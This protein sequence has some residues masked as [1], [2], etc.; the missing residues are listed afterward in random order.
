M[1]KVSRLSRILPYLTFTLLHELSHVTWHQP[2]SPAVND[3]RC[4]F[5]LNDVKLPPMKLITLHFSTQL[6]ISETSSLPLMCLSVRFISGVMGPSGARG[7]PGHPGL[8]GNAGADGPPG[9]QGYPGLEGP[10]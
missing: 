7:C 1:N 5:S 9:P 2:R 6:E 4:S 10:N 3:D 8:P